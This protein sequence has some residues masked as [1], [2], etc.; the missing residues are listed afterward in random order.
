MAIHRHALRRQ[1]KKARIFGRYKKE[2]EAKAHA[3]T[4]HGA[5][6]QK[7]K[8]GYVVIRKGHK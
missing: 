3:K 4:I 8:G 1:G 2:S 5:K 6:A 7:C